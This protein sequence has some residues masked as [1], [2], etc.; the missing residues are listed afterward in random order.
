MLFLCDLTISYYARPFTFQM[1]F[2]VRHYRLWARPTDNGHGHAKIKNHSRR[3]RWRKGWIYSVA[4][5][6]CR[7][8]RD[9]C[10]YSWG[11]GLAIAI[12]VINPTTGIPSSCSLYTFLDENWIIPG[13]VISWEKFWQS[14]KNPKMKFDYCHGSSE[15][16]AYYIYLCHTMPKIRTNNQSVVYNFLFI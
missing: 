15:Q 12:D 14:R 16:L 6:G 10:I 13:P 3:R 11:L 7:L 9:F 5:E 4:G 8:P 2:S 1:S